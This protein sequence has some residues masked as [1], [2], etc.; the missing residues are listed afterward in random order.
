MAKQ[1]QTAAPARDTA[2]RDAAADRDA[3]AANWRSSADVVDEL[4]TEPIVD[5][6]P[7]SDTP[8]HPSAGSLKESD[9][10][11]LPTSDDA[12]PND[13]PVRTN[14]PDVPIIQRLATGAGQHKPLNDPEMDPDGRLRPD[15]LTRAARRSDRTQR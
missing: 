9:K 11:N 14:R 15:V 6:A 4:N 12:E 7:T 3:A 13:P 1:T 8:K 5:D 10:T 2:A